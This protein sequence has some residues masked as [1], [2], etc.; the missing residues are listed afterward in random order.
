MRSQP[1]GLEGSTPEKRQLASSPRPLA[2]RS[3]WTNEGG[4]LRI[5]A[6]DK[7][8]LAE[9]TALGLT[10]RNTHLPHSA[11]PAPAHPHSAWQAGQAPEVH[12]AE[13]LLRIRASRCT[14]PNLGPSHPIFGEQKKKAAQELYPCSEKQNG[15]WEPSEAPWML[16]VAWPRY[17]AL[18]LC[19]TTAQ[20]RDGGDC[21]P[22]LSAGSTQPQKMGTGRAPAGAL[23]RGLLCF[24]QPC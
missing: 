13:G 15:L 16:Y 17:E 24:K 10:D 4:H 8:D 7:T 14:K 2:L 3:Y 21:A 1:P 18:G 20:S 12:L 11:V 23:T 19:G 22:P 5:S 9:M 6:I